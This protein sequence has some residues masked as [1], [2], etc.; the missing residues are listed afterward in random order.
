MLLRLSES[1]RA[2]GDLR[3]HPVP[4][5]ES[6]RTRQVYRR[7]RYHRSQICFY[8]RM[9]GHD[10]FVTFGYCNLQ[11]FRSSRRIESESSKIAC[12]KWHNQISSMH[13]YKAESNSCSPLGCDELFQAH[14]GDSQ[15]VHCDP[16]QK[17]RSNN[18]ISFDGSLKHVPEE[19]LAR[20][21]HFSLP[22][23]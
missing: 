7:R 10:F 13:K 15:L 19:R 20:Q 21:N 16:R 9:C 14:E 22:T 18:L 8:T 17:P 6:P 2:A 11:I 5:L 3:I 1:R 4:Q 23:S 12:R